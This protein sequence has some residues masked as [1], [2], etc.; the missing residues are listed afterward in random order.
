MVEIQERDRLAVY[1]NVGEVVDWFL[2]GAPLS[3]EIR[4][5]MENG[6]VEVSRVESADADKFRAEKA[7]DTGYRARMTSAPA[8]RA[9]PMSRR[10]TG[11]RGGGTSGYS[12]T[13]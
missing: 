1:Y 4:T 6:R 13:E 2:R 3:P 9:D 12:P 5:R 10:R 11:L 7:P 8:R